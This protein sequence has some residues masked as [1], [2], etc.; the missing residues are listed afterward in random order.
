MQSIESTAA[1]VAMEDALAR[2]MSNAATGEPRIP[3]KWEP[4]VYVPPN[5]AARRRQTGKNK[6]GAIR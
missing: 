2:S 3:L 4:P 6:R 1:A 5:R